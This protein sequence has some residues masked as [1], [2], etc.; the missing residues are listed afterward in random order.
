MIESDIYI[1]KNSFSFI[2]LQSK[3]ICRNN[4]CCFNIPELSRGLKRR[5][6]II[7]K[8]T[9]QVNVDAEQLKQQA[10]D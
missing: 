10:R 4:S 1:L 7:L 8:E 5:F 2:E 6:E 3:Q 9:K